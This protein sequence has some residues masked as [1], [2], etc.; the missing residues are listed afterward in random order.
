MGLKKGQSNNRS[1]RPKGT[2]N[3]VTTGLREFVSE[4]INDNREIIKADLN[5]IVDPAQRLSILERYLQYSLPKLQS[6]DVTAQIDAQVS[7]EYSALEKLLND[8]PDEAVQRIADKV[9]E[10]S[11]RNK[12]QDE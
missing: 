11:N 10:L 7:A 6:I 8:A 3:R 1:G 2:P 5:R 4:L 9:M 12:E